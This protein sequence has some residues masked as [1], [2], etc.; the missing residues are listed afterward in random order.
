MGYYTRY[1]LSWTNQGWVPPEGTTLDGLV[2]DYIDEHEHGRVM[3]RDGR[4]EEP[5]LQ[6]HDCDADMAALSRAFPRVLFH[7]EGEGDEAGDIWDLYALD[8]MIQQHQAKVV[9]VEAPN[10]HGWHVPGVSR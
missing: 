2:G 6:W 5:S 1:S 4:A 9:R 3:R 10:A 7:L 8:G